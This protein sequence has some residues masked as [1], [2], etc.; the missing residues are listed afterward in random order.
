MEGM[1]A[2]FERDRLAHELGI[3]LVSAGEGTATTRLVLGPRHLNSA[4]AAHGGAIFALADAAFSVASN[5]RGAPAA[6]IDAHIN[7][8]K[9][10]SEGALTAEARE[11]SFHPKIASYAIVVTDERGDKVAVFQGL[12]YRKVERR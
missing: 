4:G 7:Y 2:F 6:A 11:E 1:R 12:V 8:F 10:V 5:S 9:G 3:E